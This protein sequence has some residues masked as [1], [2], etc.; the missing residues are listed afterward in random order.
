MTR[1]RVGLTAVAL[2]SA[3]AVTGCAAPGSP[4]SAS[5]TPASTP[6][7]APSATSPATP[8]SASVAGPLTPVVPQPLTEASVSAETSRLADAIQALVDPAF[9]VN[10][11]DHS[12]IVDKTDGTGRYF[13]VIR[14]LT[15]QPKTDAGAAAT[16]IVTALQ[17]AGWST[18]KMP[19]EGKASVAALTSGPDPA[20]AWFAIVGADASVAGESVLSIQLASPDIA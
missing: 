15:L 3:L 10:V 12:Q 4:S 6:A 16:T 20:A 14:T 19:E 11:D 5:S 2:V 7:A 1:A 13:G 17:A 18:R 8:P 9:V